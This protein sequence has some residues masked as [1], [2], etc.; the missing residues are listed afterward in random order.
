MGQPVSIYGSNVRDYGPITPSDTVD[1]TKQ[2]IGIIVTGVAGSIAV[3]KPNGVSETIPSSMI[4]VGAIL[5]LPVKRVKA[6]GTT[7]TNI[8]AVYGS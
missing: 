4:T 8:W 5:P 3:V 7:A 6:T 2:A 1:L